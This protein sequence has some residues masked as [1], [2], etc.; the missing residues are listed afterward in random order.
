MEMAFSA[1]FGFFE[2]SLINRDQE[3]SLYSHVIIL[4][5]ILVDFQTDL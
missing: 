4:F 2:G 5:F 1:L 3:T